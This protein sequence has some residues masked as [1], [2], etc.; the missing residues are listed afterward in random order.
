MALLEL[1]HGADDERTLRAGNR[2]AAAL[3]SLRSDESE[4]TIEALVHDSARVLG[5][6]HEITLDA[7]R[8]AAYGH[9]QR[10]EYALAVE[11][12]RPVLALADEALGAD[13][14]VTLTARQNLA[15]SLFLQW[16]ATRADP[17][18][19]VESR[20]EYEHL[21]EIATN[22]GGADAPRALAA[23]AGLARLLN[24][25]DDRSEAERQARRV[26]EHVPASIGEHHPSASMA[27]T[28]LAVALDN[29]HRDAEAVEWWLRE[30]ETRRA[31]E[32]PESLAVLTGMSGALPALI[33]AGQDDLAESYARTLLDRL[34]MFGPEHP[35]TLRHQAQ[36]ARAL[37]RQGRLEEARADVDA[38]E[39]TLAGL[40]DPLPY[41]RAL[42]DLS[43][44]ELLTAAGEYEEA[45]AHLLSAADPGAFVAERRRH[46]QAVTAL[47]LVDLY[48]RW[49]RPEDAAAWRDR[50][51]PALARG[52]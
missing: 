46:H 18:P 7:R 6:R 31:I 9:R 11:G 24:A 15:E 51:P 26:L 10:G 27:R 14:R 8:M 50:L 25:A 40:E 39:A 45:E 32:G 34:A 47:A 37:T 19:L 20:R 35:T 30:I 52:P 43:H 3:L 21:I 16:Y 17:A 23:M 12:F 29:Q 44:G 22:H 36:L 33:G 38:L 42:T 48:E 1:E 41:P 49:G 28:Q 5:E 4:A 13:H 2:L